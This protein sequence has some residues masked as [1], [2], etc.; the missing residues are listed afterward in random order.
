MNAPPVRWGHPSGPV[1]LKLDARSE[2]GATLVFIT[3]HRIV[4]FQIPAGEQ[5]HHY[6]R[7]TH[8]VYGEKV[9][10]FQNLLERVEVDGIGFEVIESVEGPF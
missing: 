3:E 5:W 10:L 8:M 6:T 9:N 2:K 1:V 7:D 4:E